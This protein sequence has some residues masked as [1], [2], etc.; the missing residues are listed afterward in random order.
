MQTPYKITEEAWKELTIEL[1]R[2]RSELRQALAIVRAMNE[3]VDALLG[4]VDKKCL[5][6]PTAS[7]LRLALTAEVLKRM[8]LNDSEGDDND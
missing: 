7:D 5:Y 6:P 8:G 2:T 4:M 1:P 3:A